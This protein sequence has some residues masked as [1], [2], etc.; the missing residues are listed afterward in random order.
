MI[1]RAAGETLVKRARSAGRSLP[2]VSVTFAYTVVARMRSTVG[3][4]ESSM[5]S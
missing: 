5:S 2:T 3:L 1:A 4:S